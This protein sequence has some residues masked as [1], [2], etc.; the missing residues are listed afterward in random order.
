MTSVI[1]TNIRL[2]LIFR[3]W[4]TAYLIIIN[5]EGEHVLENFTLIDTTRGRVVAAF[6][7]LE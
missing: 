6:L 2:R 1:S 5:A 7:Y 3:H 4:P